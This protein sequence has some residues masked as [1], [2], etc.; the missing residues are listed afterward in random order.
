MLL[1]LNSSESRG[2]RKIVQI[3][4][5]SATFLIKEITNRMIQKFLNLCM[6]QF[7]IRK[8]VYDKTVLLKTL[9]PSTSECSSGVRNENSA[10]SRTLDTSDE[11]MV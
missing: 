3:F 7:L 5:V 10:V 6:I 2:D 8:G 4:F 9:L 11:D 1:L